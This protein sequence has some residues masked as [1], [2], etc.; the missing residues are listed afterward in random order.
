MSY[1]Q[2]VEPT[3]DG[4]TEEEREA[5]REAIE[6][7]R[8]AAEERR[9]AQEDQARV[10]REAQEADDA[11]RPYPERLTEQRCMTCHAANDFD[12]EQR[13]WPGWAF[14]VWRME[15]AYGADLEAGE[16][17]VISDHLAEEH[18]APPVRAAA[19]W[20]ALGMGPMV[21]VALIWFIRH[22]RR[23]AP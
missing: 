21:T 23:N 9:R 4:M 18:A 1:D 8:Q 11:S 15:L 22:R 3:D 19:V 14:T 12:K 13:S 20:A 2:L 16:W 7:D 10:E 5:R 6:R 17:R